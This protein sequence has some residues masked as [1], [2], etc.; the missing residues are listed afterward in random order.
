VIPLIKR[1]RDRIG[2]A[3]RG[4]YD[5]VKYWSTRASDSG[6]TSVMWTNLTYNELVDRDEWKVIERYLP[7]QRGAVLDI[8]CGTGRLSARLASKFD[9][10]TGVDLPPMAEEAERRNP[11]L[12]GSFVGANVEEYEYPPD[13]F[14]FV[15]SLGCLSTAVTAD[16]LRRLASRIVGTAKKGGRIAL[17]EPF[18]RN[19]VLTR[20][21]RISRGE[22]IDL[23]EGLGT[24]LHAKDGMIFPPLRLLLSE[25]MFGGVPTITKIG[26][27]LGERVVRLGPNVLS[28]YAILVLDK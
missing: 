18:H 2:F 21:C 24:R 11:S 27:E 3:G 7:E 6:S 10:Y 14:D 17:I 20:G 16:G 25:R 26:Y 5:P 4:N 13:T 9:R 23:F 22:T 19:P 28:D 15:L 1:I 12:A 8:G